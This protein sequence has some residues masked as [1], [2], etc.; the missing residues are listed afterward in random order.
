MQIEGMSKQKYH[1]RHAPKKGMCVIDLAGA[2]K[3]IGMA[4]GTDEI[5]SVHL[6][7]NQGIWLLWGERQRNQ[8][9]GKARLILVQEFLIL[10]RTEAG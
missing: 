7:Q 6:I 4:S 5:G 1:S 3:E 9:S 10:D 2:K 8:R